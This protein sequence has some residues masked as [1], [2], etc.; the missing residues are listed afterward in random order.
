MGEGV[1]ASM[2]VRFGYI[3][4]GLCTSQERTFFTIGVLEALSPGCGD[5]IR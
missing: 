1:E 4:A 2:I 5:P 3:Y